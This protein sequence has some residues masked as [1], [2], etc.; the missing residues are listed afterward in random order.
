MSSRKRSKKPKPYIEYTVR[1]PSF[2]DEYISDFVAEENKKR[3]E[4]KDKINNDALVNMIIR[5][6][7]IANTV[8][9]ISKAASDSAVKQHVANVTKAYL[10]T[11]KVK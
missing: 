9:M 3:T 2:V 11:F 6:W 4:P 10:Q 1:V 7:Y 5:D 8:P